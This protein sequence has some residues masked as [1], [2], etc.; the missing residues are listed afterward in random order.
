MI[1]ALEYHYAVL[2]AHMALRDGKSLAEVEAAAEALRRANLTHALLKH[3]E[4]KAARLK[5]TA[6]RVRGLLP[7]KPG[8]KSRSIN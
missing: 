5:A 6:G 4:F 3:L 8:P 7:G 2:A 1:D